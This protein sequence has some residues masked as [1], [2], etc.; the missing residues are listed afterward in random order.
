[1]TYNQ[2]S[3]PKKAKDFDFTLI[4]LENDAESVNFTNSS[5]QPYD[6]FINMSTFGRWPPGVGITLRVSVSQSSMSFRY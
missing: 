4:E 2:D 1:M 5:P 6:F 3:S